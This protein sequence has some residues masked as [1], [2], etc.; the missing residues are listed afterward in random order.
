ME[1]ADAE[2]V[3]ALLNDM[4]GD[5]RGHVVSERWWMVWIVMGIQILITSVITQLVRWSGEQNNGVY[6]VIWGTH[7]AL[8]APIIF[9]IHRYSGGQR[10][11]SEV[12][13]W[14]IWATFIVCSTITA[15]FS[16]LIT[17]PI[18][19]AAPL[20]A[21]LAT[22]AFSMMAM[23]SHRFFLICAAIFLGVMLSMTLLPQVEF[24]IFGGAW[25]AVL[26]T[27]GIHFRATMQPHSGRRL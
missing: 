17:E 2:R 6:L 7:V 27:L 22:F 26:V 14:W 8:I 23:V 21:L 5:L 16:Q 20:V 18:K 13:I 3:F 9:Y 12:Y 4:N 24:L 1:R 15:F 10:T 25:F 19:S 11:A